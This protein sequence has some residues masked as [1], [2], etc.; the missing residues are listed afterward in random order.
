MAGKKIVTYTYVLTKPMQSIA[1]GKIIQTSINLDKHK[2]IDSF[3]E[4]LCQA[5]IITEDE[6]KEYASAYHKQES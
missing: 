3:L 2:T 6:S 1:D 4:A 5:G